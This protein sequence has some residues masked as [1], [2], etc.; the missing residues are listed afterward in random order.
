MA[1]GNAPDVSCWQGY[2]S[3]CNA[4][5]R[6]EFFCQSPHI[7][8]CLAFLTFCTSDIRHENSSTS[9]SRLIGPTGAAE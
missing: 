6:T 3:V 2:L 5:Q 1:Y 7:Q 8:A 9:T 4:L